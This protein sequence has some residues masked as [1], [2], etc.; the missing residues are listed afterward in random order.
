[1]PVFEYFCHKCGS[2][3]E[4]YVRHWDDPAP[5][6]ACGMER[7]KMM[8][9]FGIVFTGPITR[10][11]MDT[12]RDGY[13]MEG[14]WAYRKRSSISGQPEPVFIS[15]FDELKAFN[16]AEGLAA[17]GEVPTNAT[18]SADGRKLTSSGMP[19]QWQCGMPPI[20]SRLQEIIDMPAENIK[21]SPATVT[22]RMPIDYG[23]KIQAVDPKTMQRIEE[24]G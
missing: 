24:N 7:E 9:R 17:P 20:P 3:E 10:K 15:T 23:I 14:F 5:C 4:I 8:S 2:T 22:P 16:K 6:P 11:Y 19:G 12:K 18:I 1:M 13:H 21:P